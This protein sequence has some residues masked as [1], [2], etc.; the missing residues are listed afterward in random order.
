MEFGRKYDSTRYSLAWALTFGFISFNIIAHA[1]VACPACAA[2]FPLLILSSSLTTRTS[3][4]SS[5]RL[6]FTLAISE[7]KAAA[8]SSASESLSLAP[9]SESDEPG[10]VGA[11]PFFSTLDE[12]DNVRR[13]VTSADL[14]EARRACA[15]YPRENAKTEIA[16]GW[17]RAAGCKR[18]IRRNVTI[19]FEVSDHDPR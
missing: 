4:T 5:T 6:A 3:L 17:R 2:I 16:I 11:E 10:E 1:N 7:T 18:G 12:V 13:G 19:H 8:S 9:I 15:E 14:G